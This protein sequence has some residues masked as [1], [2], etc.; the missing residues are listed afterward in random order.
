[1]SELVICNKS[2]LVSVANAIRISS[3][4]TDTMSFP[5]GMIDAIETCGSGNGNSL[6][7]SN[8]VNF[9]DYDGTVLY[10][11]TATEFAALSALPANPTHSGLTSQGWNWSLSDAQAYVA[12]YGKLWIGQM[13]VTDDGKT[14]IYIH[15]EEGRTSPML[16]CCLKGTVTVDW[17]DGTDIDTLTGTTG[18]VQWT[19]NHAYETAGDYMITLTVESG[20]I[21]F[22]G[23]GSTNMWGYLLRHSSSADARNCV[24]KSSIRKIELGNG[25]TSIGS[26]AFMECYNLSSITIPNTITSIGAYA[27]GRCYNLYSIAIP[28]KVTSIATYTFE[29]CCNLNSIAIP[30][31]VKSIGTYAFEYCHSLSSIAIPN[32]VTSIG[33]N[34]FESCY[35]LSNITIPNTVTSI[36]NYSFSGCYS[37]SNITIPD[38]FKSIGTAMFQNCYSL[39]N[40]TI[41]N[42]VT[43]IGNYSFNN[44]SSLSSVVIPNTVTSIGTNT[45]Y[46]CYGVVFYDFSTHTSIPTLSAT[47]A[48]QNIAADCEIRV[49]SS[50]YDEWI[51]ATNWSTYASKIVAV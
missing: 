12:T 44:C 46:N 17:G 4:T 42:T 16:G 5:N 19:G 45:F 36:G 27:F 29:Y 31:T 9:I 30:N 2:D 14:R 15:L 41:P 8:D 23:Q 43:S 18:S 6:V 48:F 22:G 28:N 10:S 37:L 47:S 40:I 32:K 1:M 20:N 39:S 24:Y 35:S 34:A 26:Y 51:A 13:Y 21:W 50:L 38:A 33:T 25:V 11:Y 3:G 49:P 7:E